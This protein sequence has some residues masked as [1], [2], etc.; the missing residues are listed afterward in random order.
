[1]DFS[2]ILGLVEALLA[3]MMMGPFVTMTMDY[4][5]WGDTIL[6]RVN[7]FSLLACLIFSV[8]NL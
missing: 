5:V 2:N 8:I 3:V 4:E 6:A 1:M 7:I